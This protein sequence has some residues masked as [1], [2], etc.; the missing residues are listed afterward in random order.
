[1]QTEIGN[2]TF[3]YPIMN[4]SGC[5]CTTEKELIELS[6]S[7]AGAVISKSCTL[8]SREGNPLP[9]YYH[10]DNLSINS[11][12][13]ANNGYRFYE[14]IGSKIMTNKPYIISVAGIEKGD[15][16][17]IIQDLQDSFTSGSF[18]MIELNLS[19]P[20]IIGKPQIAYDFKA[21]EELLRKV[22]ELNGDLNTNC[23]HNHKMGLKLPPYFDISHFNSMADILSEF[24]SS[25][26][27]C[28]NS[29]GHGFV[30]N[31]DYQP[32]ILPRNG[33]GG[34]G[35]SVI[36]P[37]GLSNVRQF[38]ELLPS[39]DIIGCGGVS[40]GRDLHEYLLCGA[41]VVQ[42]GTQL[43]REGPKCFDRILDEYSVITK[44]N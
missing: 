36:K 26:I 21:T 20:N 13:L 16:I 5:W 34:I 33:Y 25:Y 11:T 44:K 1:M 10:T 2:I 3:E 40:T 6:K 22:S 28:I 39:L 41:K 38:H 4:A 7:T 35:G 18:N 12:G 19:C 8:N 30:F 32:S 24:K 9:R 29:I 31:E 15:N 37:I 43:V 27:T 17:K 23:N 42:V 14:Q